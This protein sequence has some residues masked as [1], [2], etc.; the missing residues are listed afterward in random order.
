M[1][2]KKAAGSDL[3]GKAV[4]SLELPATGDKKLNL[5]AMKGSRIV[6]YFYPKDNTSGCTIEG[7]D[8]NKLKAKF[9]KAKCEILGVSR[10]SV[11]SHEGFCAKQGFTFDLISDADEKLCKYF[12]VIKMKSLYGKKFLGIERSTFVIDEKGKI[13]REWRKV[14]VDG[15]AKEVLEFVES[16]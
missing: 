2:R 15:H 6:L 16:L 4:P 13:V 11:K 8:F 7:Q 3:I 10:D 12:D 9:A 14:K 1:T 5:K